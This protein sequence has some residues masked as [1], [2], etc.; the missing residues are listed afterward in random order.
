MKSLLIVESPTK[1]KTLSK[2]LG[3]NFTIKASVGHI[4]DLPKKD[5][6][7]DIEN[8]L[9]P[10]YVVI[11]GKEKVL[12]DLK[13]AAKTADKIFLGPDPDREG[14]AIAWHIATELNGASDKVFRVEFNEIT[15]KAV[16]EAI[17]H[18]R[19]I[20]MNLVDA[21]QAR[22]VLDRL[23]G[24][25]L[26]PLLWRKVR[27]GLSAGRVQSVAVRLVVDREREIEAFK[28]REY[29]SITAS[30]EGKE[31]PP[32]DAK[33]FHINDEKAD[34][35][36]EKQAK[37]ILND[38]EGRSFNVKKVE[39][40]NRRRSPAP[41][42][43]TST[44]QQ[45]A[46]RKLR[47]TA[48][49]TMMTAQQ[50]YEG[51]ELG[52]EGSVGLITYMRTD[53]VKVAS[54]AQEEAR[55]LI[56]GEFGKDYV[57]QK[58]P[59]Y[60]S[61]KSAQEAHEAIRP[62]S[63]IRTPNSLKSYLSRDKY[64]LYKL[65]WNRFIA[66]Q[67]HVALLEQTSIDIAPDPGD[68]REGNTYIFRATGTVIKFPGFMKLYTEG[69]DNGPV[70]E[71][72][73]PALS[74]GDVLRTLGIAPRQ[75]FT[76]PPP[77]YS[78]ATL[79]KEL[80]AKGI[81]RPST[82]ATILSTIQD[83]KY[84][85][86]TEGKFKPTELGML[87][88]DLLVE[89]FSELM[90]FSFTAKMED[91]LDRIEE[92][93]L[94]WVDIVMDFYEPFDRDLLEAMES[95]GKVKPE[96]IPTDEICDKCGN[97]MVIKWGRHGRFI[98]CT[99]YPQCKNTKPLEQQEAGSNGQGTSG[100]ETGETCEKCGSPMVLKS[101]KFGRFLACSKYPD[102]KST[103]PIGTGIQC[104]DDGGEI[105]ERST[106]KGKVFYSCGNYPKCKFATWYKPVNKKCPDCDAAF[107]VEKR[108]KQGEYLTC[109]KKGCKYKEELQE[110]GID[111]A[112]ES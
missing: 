12:K 46:S 4:K 79:V 17:K 48:K 54:E 80:E 109:L 14:E 34:I 98:A 81:G 53:S 24:Y 26:S 60:K 25:K 33:L 29:W 90:D 3:K 73:L 70:E 67:M 16:T 95:L 69:G 52:G 1:V 78:E 9:S 28:P 84:T 72:L 63:V 71:G 101:G 19:K 35:K 56:R 15:E 39:K 68:I 20:D 58:L 94:K 93:G 55:A 43:I 23:V 30:L 59:V 31:P 92:G 105:V 7:V 47:F 62:T 38:L 21:Q 99:G 65:I 22:R 40:K 107:L 108:T 102:C 103:K 27:R 76:Q 32:F 87:V 85:E 91:N 6:G 112:V 45:E 49:K 11:E 10:T 88:S 57:P 5:L 37:G 77:R 83:R 51:I 44:L 42:F 97:P 89:R 41:P 61:K 66:S 104:P 74:E 86:K 18:P 64:N 2:F 111:Q 13:K 106:R 96:D 82:Y 110:A 100:E 36:N 50:L 8:N 75:H